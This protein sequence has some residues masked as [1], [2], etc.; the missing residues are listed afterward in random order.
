MAAKRPGDQGSAELTEFMPGPCGGGFANSAYVQHRIKERIMDPQ[1]LPVAAQAIYNTIKGQYKVGFEPLQFGGIRLNLL[2][3]SDLEQLLD[4]KDALKNVSDFPF[5]V[6]LWEAAIVLAQFLAGQKYSDNASLI[7][8]GA[9]LGVPG[10][11]AAAAGCPVTLT[12]YEDLILDFERVSAA[13]SGLDNVAF[14]IL[15]WKNPPELKQYDIIAGAEILFREEFFEPLLNVMRRLLKPDGV[16]YLAHDIK[17]KSLK[18]FLQM[19]E[20]EYNIAASRR[21]LKSLEEDKVILLN[22][23]TPRK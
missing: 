8:L 10:L 16:I 9:G 12:D 11:V 20:A 2:T 18:P 22:R 14:E 4:G 17:R 6:K 1:T 3:V 7:E 23:L 15:D 5:W 21:T 13:A 19:A